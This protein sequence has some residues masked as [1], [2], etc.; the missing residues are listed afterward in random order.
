MYGQY[1]DAPFRKAKVFYTGTD[2]IKKGQGLCYDA[3]YTSSISGEAATD[4]CTLRQ[5]R[6]ELPTASN[7]R[8]FAGVAAKSYSA[9]SLGQE[10]EIYLPGGMAYVLIGGN[11]KALPGSASVGS[12]VTCAAGG[13]DA[14]RF[15]FA[16]L[17]GRGTA[18]VLETDAGAVKFTSVDGSATAAYSGGVTTI[19]KT[20]IGDACEAGDRVVILA[21]ADNATGGDASSG[22]LAT[23]GIYDVVSAP[24]SDTITIAT[25]IG[26]VD[27]CL[28]VLDDAEHVVLARLMDGEESG[29]QQFITPQDATAVSAM[30][31][32]VTYVTGGWTMAA[33]S[34]FTLAD[35]DVEGLKKAFVCLGTLTTKD[36]K[37]TVTSGLQGDVST[38]LASFTMDAANEQCVLQWHGNCGIG[39]GGTWVIINQ[40]GVGIA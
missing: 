9:N 3:D 29:L 17:P 21:G 1:E 35:G 38:G 31:G 14:G 22:E 19:T 18:E 26:D 16:G 25:D 4:P 5:F 28:Y 15:T 2:A 11:D 37:V 33:D 7:N 40:A 34:T 13:P 30:V 8:R 10:I 27:V 6:V 24:T 39:S 23:T 36:Y 32:G 20:G 12:I